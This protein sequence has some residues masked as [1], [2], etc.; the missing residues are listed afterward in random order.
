MMSED[1]MSDQE[2]Q[3]SATAPEPTVTVATPPKTAEAEQ[4][5]RMPRSF[6]F[7]GAVIGE[8]P[9]ARWLVPVSDLVNRHFLVATV[10]LWVVLVVSALLGW[11][12]P[13]VVAY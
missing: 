7:A 3:P 6:E 9:L 13:A 1:A 5:V 2:A 11:L 10:A 12:W 4:P 8:R